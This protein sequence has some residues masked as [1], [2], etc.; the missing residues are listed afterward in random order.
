MR[1]QLRD[2]W[3]GQADIFR[4]GYIVYTSGASGEGTVIGVLAILVAKCADRS[5]ELF[6]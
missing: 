2:I 6:K 5:Q 3:S 1:H 4:A